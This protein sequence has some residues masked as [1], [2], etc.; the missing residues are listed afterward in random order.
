MGCLRCVVQGSSFLW[1]KKLQALRFSKYEWLRFIELSPRCHSTHKFYI[2]MGGV[3][4][5]VNPIG[6]N[7]VEWGGVEE[8]WSVVEF[9]NRIGV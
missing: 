7:G 5:F 9:L 3:V 8:E 2:V 4:E 1:T 6:V